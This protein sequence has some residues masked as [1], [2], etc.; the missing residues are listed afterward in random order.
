MPFQNFQYPANRLTYTLLCIITDIWFMGD[1]IV[2]RAHNYAITDNFT[3]TDKNV[4]WCGKSGMRWEG[5]LQTIQLQML[6]NPPPKILI[7]HLGG[8]NIHNTKITKLISAINKD[9]KYLRDTLLDTHIIWCDILPRLQWRNNLSESPKLLNIKRKRI[10]RAA[11]QFLRLLENTSVISPNI[12]WHMSELFM[13]DG[14]HLSD[15]GNMVYL[16]TIK[17]HLKNVT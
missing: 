7:I 1:S 6:H 15:M 4:W 9:I 5:L 11:H 16:Q 17:V 3:L 12:P 8:N 2:K 13:T 10:N 14:V